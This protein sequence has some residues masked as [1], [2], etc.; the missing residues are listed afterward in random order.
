MC[1]GGVAILVHEEL[2]RHIKKIERVGRRILKITLTSKKA[3]T[4]ITTLETYAP[5]SGYTV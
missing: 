3:T 5:Q 4:P 1:H 2:H